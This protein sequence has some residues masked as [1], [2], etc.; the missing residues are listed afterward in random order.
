MRLL[1]C[2]SVYWLGINAVIETHKKLFKMFGI[3]AN[4]IEG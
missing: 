1:P 2:E 4:T 3:M